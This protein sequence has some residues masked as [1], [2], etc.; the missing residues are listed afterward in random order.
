MLANSKFNKTY[1][2]SRLEL[3]DKKCME[4]ADVYEHLREQ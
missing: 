1:S 3:L 4:T 2:E